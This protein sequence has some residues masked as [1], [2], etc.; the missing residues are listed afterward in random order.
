MKTLTTFICAL[1]LSAGSLVAQEI[2]KPQVKLLLSAGETVLGQE[3]TYP[4]DPAQITTAIVTLPP[5]GQTGWHHHTVP[6]VG[7]MLEGELT[8]DYGE[9][10]TR[11]YTAGE[12]VYEAMATSHNGQNTGDVPVRILVVF[13][14]AKGIPNSV[15]DQ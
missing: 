5:N 4:S 15:A 7:Y 13:A 12:A 1:C 11:T 10:G 2:P 6:L 3:I 9:H 8:V 14:G